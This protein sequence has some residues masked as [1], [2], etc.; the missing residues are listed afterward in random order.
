MAEQ[1]RELKRKQ[2]ELK[3]SNAH[4]ETMAFPTRSRTAEPAAI[5]I[6]LHEA[7]DQANA[8]GH[9]LALFIDP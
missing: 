3:A 9:P 8:T 1:N 5:R 4:L 6:A 2:Y 7:I